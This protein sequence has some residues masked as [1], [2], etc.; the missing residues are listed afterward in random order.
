MYPN[1]EGMLGKERNNPVNIKYFQRKNQDEY[2]AGTVESLPGVF[3]IRTHKY[4]FKTKIVTDFPGLEIQSLL[5]DSSGI[6]PGR[7]CL[8]ERN[9]KSV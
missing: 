2:Y 1:P 7:S 5:A 3:N 8:S 6:W 4:S 9:Q